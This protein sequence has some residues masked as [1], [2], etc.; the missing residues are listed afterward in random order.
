MSLVRRLSIATPT[1]RYEGISVSRRAAGS[2]LSPLKLCAFKM[3]LTIKTASPDSKGHDA[4][5]RIRDEYIL[6]DFAGTFFPPQG[7][8]FLSG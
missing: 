5:E 2:R 3:A 6:I 1:P 7:P 8:I 4:V